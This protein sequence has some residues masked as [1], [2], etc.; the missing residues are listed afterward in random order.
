LGAALPK[1]LGVRATR[2]IYQQTTGLPVLAGPCRVGQR[3]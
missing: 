1:L 2:S 3:S